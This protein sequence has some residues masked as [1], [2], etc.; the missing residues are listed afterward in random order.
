MKYD[1]KNYREQTV[2]I[3]TLI[4]L[5]LAVIITS[6]VFNPKILNYSHSTSS[7]KNDIEFTTVEG[8][9]FTMGNK[10]NDGRINETPIKQVYVKTFQ[11]SKYEITNEQFCNFLNVNGNTLDAGGHPLLDIE[12]P[13]CNIERVDERYVP[14]KGK[15]M[16]PVIEVS[17]Y[18]AKAYAKWVNSRLPT[19]E[20]WE[21]AASC[22][23]KFN[24][25]TY[26][27]RLD[28][29]HANIKGTSLVDRWNGTSPVGSFPPNELGLFDMAGNI[30]EWCESTYKLYNSD[31]LH[32]PVDQ[33]LGHVKVVRG[34]S[35]SFKKELATVTYRAREYASYWSYD[36]GFRIA[37]SLE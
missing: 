13:Y 4:I 33:K 9:T 22:R 2:L 19:E 10:R 15:A 18:G 11:I 17:W 36:N 30:W 16:H 27:N 21:F 7:D 8:G 20:E 5:L 34:G 37:R 35:W 26:G 31:T 12:S 6:F 14:K 25:Y 32:D 29:N 28:N 1:F 23:G 24:K 3:M